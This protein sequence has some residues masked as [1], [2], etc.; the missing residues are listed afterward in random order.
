MSA[1][2][3]FRERHGLSQV[4][5]AAALGMSRRAV[6]EHEQGGGLPR[7]LALALR[8]LEAEITE[9]QKSS[10]ETNR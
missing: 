10:A 6:Q 7:R 5:L 3:D 9:G 8:G 1:I 4:E 2:R